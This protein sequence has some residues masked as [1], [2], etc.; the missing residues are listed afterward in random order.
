V[1][2]EE[3]SPHRAIADPKGRGNLSQAIAY[4]CGATI[5]PQPL[6]GCQANIIGFGDRAIITVN[7]KSIR[8]RQRFSSGHEPGHWMKDRGQNAFG[9]LDSQTQR[10]FSGR[11]FD[12]W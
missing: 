11:R 4:A 8:T 7:S 12:S 1:R 5:L 9:C 10:K 3:P 6:T 2:G